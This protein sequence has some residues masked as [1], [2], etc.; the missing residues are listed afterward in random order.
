M[1]APR[2]RRHSGLLLFSGVDAPGQSDAIFSAL[3][4]Y[5]ID[6]IDIEQVV[7]SKRLLLTILIS[8]DPAHSS[9]IERELQVVA[10]DKNLDFAAEFTALSEESELVVERL[11]LVALGSPLSPQAVSVVAHAI[12]ANNG[13]IDRIHRTVSYPVTA[14]EFVI[15]LP[16][17]QR[18]DLIR[19]L[20]KL[21]RENGFDFSVENE[22]LRRGAKRLVLL[23]VDSTLIQ[24]EVI[25]LLGARTEH[26]AEIIEITSRAMKGELT[27]DEALRARVA[28]LKGLSADVLD[29]VRAEISLSPGAR[30]LIRTLHHLGHKV[31]IV[32]GGFSDVIAPLAEELKLD[33]VLANKLEVLDGYLTGN[34]VGEIVNRERKASALRE[35]AAREKIDIAQ[36]V[37]VGDGANDLEMLKLAGLGI[38]FNAKP[39]LRESADASISNPYLDS[40]LYLLGITREE[41]TQALL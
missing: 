35:F 23:D 14:F 40:V 39:I 4:S 27:F 19:E 17:D 41:V 29:D 34:V 10:T 11:H 28:L 3:A 13:N 33:F 36:T 25:D 31:G 20:N 26:K 18:E 37:A 1:S 30:T 9:A 8:L 24:Q 5:S 32:S 21:S 2:P 22:S 6:I 15:S 16:S 38:A 12:A 7:I